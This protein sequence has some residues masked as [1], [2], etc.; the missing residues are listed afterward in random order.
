MRVLGARIISAL[1][2][3]A[4]YS[5]LG[6]YIPTSPLLQPTTLT[7][8]RG[9]AA[10][11]EEESYGGDNITTNSI[12]SAPSAKDTTATAATAIA[13]LSA[14]ASTTAKVV[15]TTTNDELQ[16][17]DE[18]DEVVPLLSSLSPKATLNVATVEDQHQELALVEEQQQRRRQRFLDRVRVVSRS[19]I[20]GER[21][22]AL[23]RTPATNSSTSDTDNDDTTTITPQSDLMRPDRHMT[24][25]TTAAL[26]WMTG[27]AVNPLLRAAHLVR[28]TRRINASSNKK[29]KQWVTLVIPWLELEQ[30]RDN[31]YPHNHFDTP[32]D[33]E[34]YLRAWLT[35]EADMA[36]V[37]H[38]LRIVFYP[39]RYHADL[40]SIFAM[41]DITEYLVNDDLDD[42]E[43]HNNDICIL[44]EPEHLNWFRAPGEGWSTKFK[45]V[46][47][48]V[49]TNYKDYASSQ[50]HGL[51][52]APALA[53]ISSAMVR[54]YCHKVIKLSDV[55]QTFAPEKEST[56][57][58][59]GVRSE[60]IK[61]GMRRAA[62]DAMNKTRGAYFIGKII[63]QK[64]FDTM[65]EMQDY[66]K[67][68]TGDYFPIDI[69]GSGSD[70]K[71][72]MRAHYGRRQRNKTNTYAEATTAVESTTTA[73][74]STKKKHKKR[75]KK[76]VVETNDDDTIQHAV[77]AAGDKESGLST[78]ET[79]NGKAAGQLKKL[80]QTFREYTTSGES[81]S[82]EFNLPKT[83]HELRRQPIPAT[84]PGRIDHAELKEDYSI[85][86][87]PS[88]SEVLCTTTAEALAMGKFVIIPVHP[89][90]TFFLQFPN[91][92]AYRNKLEFVANLR[93]AQSHDPDPLTP[94]L[95]HQ[96][97][98][99]AATERLVE[100]S[101]ISVA[102][103]LERE[104][105]GRTKLDQ[106]IA[107]FHNEIGKGERGDTIRKVMGAGP[108]SHQVKYQEEQR[109]GEEADDE[110]EDDEGFSKKF[111]GSSISQ[112][113]RTTLANGLPTLIVPG[114]S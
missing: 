99:E 26:P 93:W 25:V 71:E 73:V 96:F 45:Y 37:A 87:N 63:W 103:A 28:L 61:E 14:T 1:A 21:D 22:A 83:L 108:V 104:R 44:E 56:S 68:C 102:E 23:D 41:G 77:D 78:L 27:T 107:W 47:G 84:F 60:F 48:I 62:D 55:L 66:Y 109:K 50:Y 7:S 65:L 106:R 52:T 64:G 110:E 38:D 3:G 67:Q 94:E 29:N 19:L 35:K 76:Q 12:L 34:A 4:V 114:L 54:A 51:W 74:K 111:F 100:A 24:I 33:Q 36:D 59:H 101:A 43:K 9:G 89:S 58:V 97:T 91:C 86:I 2:F 11:S 8:V 31:L 98:W 75:K 53:M 30:D 105:L 81:S 90:N 79:L 39:G 17:T 16:F 5:C 69:Y 82:L 92:L 6:S 88:V 57:N 15:T 46:V 72:I 49:H 80:K 42:D 20:L 13:T 112:A 10:G 95:H 40:K 18:L 113:L 70:Q 32:A 85:F